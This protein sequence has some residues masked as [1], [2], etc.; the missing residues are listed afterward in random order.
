MQTR[1]A[2]KT[3]ALLLASALPGAQAMADERAAVVD[4]F[5]KAMEKGRYSAEMVTEVKGRPYTTQMKVVFPD[6]FHM[7]SP[8]AEFIILPQGTWM[9]AGGQWMKMPMNMSKVI[10]GHSKQAM[11]QGMAAVVN[12]SRVG[13]AEVKGC[14]SDLYSYRAEGEYMGLKNSGDVEAAVCRDSGLPV[15]LV[16][17]GRDS[18]TIH[19]DFES[20]VEIRPPN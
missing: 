7:K 17:K 20:E 12:V 10:A 2:M 18:V 5:S 11:E 6:R 13:T 19:Y 9:N 8:D 16:S 3:L 1:F 15:R 14:T 4:A